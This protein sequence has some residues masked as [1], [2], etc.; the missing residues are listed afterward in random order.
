MDKLAPLS[1]ANDIIITAEEFPP[2]TLDAFRA[3]ISALCSNAAGARR[4]RP[5]QHRTTTATPDVRAL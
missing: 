3:G 1:R 5:L 2:A 4:H